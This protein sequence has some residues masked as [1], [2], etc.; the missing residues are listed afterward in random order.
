MAQAP[1]LLHRKSHARI[2]FHIWSTLKYDTALEKA[3]RNPHGCVPVSVY[4]PKRQ[5]EAGPAVP[6]GVC[7]PNLRGMGSVG[8]HNLGSQSVGKMGFKTHMG[9]QIR[10]LQC[11]QTGWVPFGSPLHTD[12]NR[13]HLS[14]AFET[15]WS[16]FYSGCRILYHMILTS[17]EPRKPTPTPRSRAIFSNP[18]SGPD[19][20]PP[21]RGWGRSYDYST[22]LRLCAIA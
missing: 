21:E 18:N 19:L 22:P 2:M 6:K 17:L 4:H 3:R 14:T 10:I 11:F 13:V 7:T 15:T 5:R 9:A 12:Q 16:L 20:R 1:P 8:S